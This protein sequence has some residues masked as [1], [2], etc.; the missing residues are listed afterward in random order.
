MNGKNPDGIFD[1]RVHMAELVALL[2][3]PPL[4][5]TETPQ[6]SRLG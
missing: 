1:D 3:P 6:L 2:G 4:E 5:G